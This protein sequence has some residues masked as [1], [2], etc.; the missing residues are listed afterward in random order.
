MLF[1]LE[2]ITE[3]D[4]FAIATM[5]GLGYHGLSLIFPQMTSFFH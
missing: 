2:A 5:V 1:L 3:D 4:T